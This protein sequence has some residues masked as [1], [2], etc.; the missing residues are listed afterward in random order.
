MFVPGAMAAM[1]ADMVMN[2][3]AEAARAPPGATYT[4]TGTLAP[5]IAFTIS[6]VLVT[7]PPGVSRRMTRSCAPLLAASSMPNAMYS[8][9]PGD[10]A[11]ATSSTRT[12]GVFCAAV[13]W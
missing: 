3:P 1:W 5:N 4:A 8:E 6:R 10:M 7:R 2:V 9:V 11:S 12:G 13:A